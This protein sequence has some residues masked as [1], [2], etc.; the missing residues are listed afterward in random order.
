[1]S[2]IGRAL[3][4]AALD[5]SAA[6]LIWRRSQ[7]V[8]TRVPERG[9]KPGMKSIC[10]TLLA[11]AVLAEPLAAVAAQRRP[12]HQF[13]RHQSMAGRDRANY[14]HS[15]TRGR[16]GLGANPRSPEGPGNATFR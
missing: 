13:P 9:M 11:A 1:V 3:A 12:A 6:D 2:V 7:Q 8:Q 14:H 16:M 4:A 5:P 10:A 15:G